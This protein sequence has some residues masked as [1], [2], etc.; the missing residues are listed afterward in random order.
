[1]KIDSRVFSLA[2]AYACIVPLTLPA[3]GEAISLGLPAPGSKSSE[4][5]AP[6]AG[7]LAALAGASG[8]VELS[9]IPVSSTDAESALLEPVEVFTRTT[10]TAMTAD[11]PEERPL[12]VIRFFRGETKST[13]PS[14]VFLS[15]MEGR[16]LFLSV[17]GRD[18]VLRVGAPMS[19]HDASSTAHAFGAGDGNRVTT[20]KGFCKADALLENQKKLAEFQEPAAVSKASGTLAFDLMLDIGNEL[21]VSGFGGNTVAATFYIANVIGSVSTIYKRDVDVILQIG[22]LYIWETNDEFSHLDTSSQLRSFQ[23]YCQTKRKGER[24]AVAH[25]FGGRNGLGGIAFLDALCSENSGYGVSN[26][27][28]D[29]VFPVSGY[30]WDLSVTAHEL[31]HNFGSDHTHC[32][33]PPIDCCDTECGCSPTSQGSGEIMSYCSPRRMEFSERVQA[34]IRAAAEAA[35][36]NVA[37]RPTLTEARQYLI[38]NF[39][40]ADADGSGSLSFVEATVHLPGLPQAL[41]NAIDADGNGLL[42]VAELQD[43]NGPGGCQGYR[44]SGG[45]VD[46]II[47]D[48]FA[49]FL[50]FAIMLGSHLL[51]RSKI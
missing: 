40:L 33:I 2:I 17:W 12:P 30:H 13:T 28:A 16:N 10:Y 47:G 36:C 35:S 44:A 26:L 6:P 39:N 49:L 5:F 20:P 31:G 7:A 24:R 46:K 50:G 19:V 21:F 18:G 1:M 48:W 27:D 34:V 41:F 32:Y 4:A 25:F 15:V 23:L 43:D 45:S 9:E 11:G 38:L 51:T 37:P 14:T 29:A 3:F 8:S 42:T 22:S